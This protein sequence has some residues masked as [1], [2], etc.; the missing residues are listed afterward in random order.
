MALYAMS[1]SASIVTVRSCDVM[2][3]AVSISFIDNNNNNCC[4]AGMHCLEMGQDIT[5][6]NSGITKATDNKG[7]AGDYTTKSNQKSCCTQIVL[8]SKLVAN[9]P[10]NTDINLVF[11]QGVHILPSI[12]PDY[13]TYQ[14][15]NLN[16][17]NGWRAT[18][19]PPNNQVPLYKLFKRLTYYG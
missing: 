3:V 8:Q 15:A 12:L 18:S 10:A 1:V 6:A 2:Q 7:Y 13:A 16:I 11:T 5:K 14:A 4:C 19:S 9:Q 17:Q